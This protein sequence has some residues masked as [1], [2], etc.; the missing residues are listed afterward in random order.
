MREEASRDGVF[1]GRYVDR[2]TRLD[3]LGISFCIDVSEKPMDDVVV[4]EVEAPS[5]AELERITVHE[6]T[7]D[8]SCSAVALPART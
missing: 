6:G 3:F 1:V 8:P 4:V 2:R 5:I 7:D